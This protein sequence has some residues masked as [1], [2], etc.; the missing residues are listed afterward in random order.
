MNK[1][2]TKQL[3]GDNQVYTTSNRSDIFYQLQLSQSE[4]MDT[5]FKLLYILTNVQVLRIPNA[6][7]NMHFN[8]FIGKKLKK[9]EKQQEICSKI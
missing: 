6:G 2:W 4:N 5:L 7:Q 1:M 9:E 3:S 8:G